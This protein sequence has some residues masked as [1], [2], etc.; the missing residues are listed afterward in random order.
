M[1]L[2]QLAL[3]VRPRSAWEAVDLG[4]L[5]AKR[6][7]WPLM[8]VWLLASAP[9]FVFALCMP[10]NYFWVGFILLWW[11]KPLYERPMLHILSR[12][13]FNELPSTR[14]TLQLFPALARLQLFL[15]LSVRRFSPTRSM[16]L[17]VL[18]LEGLTKARRQAR[19]SILHREDSAPAG[20]LSFIGFAL[21]IFLT[22]GLLSLL[23][24]FIPAEFDV[25]W[26]SLFGNPE[27]KSLLYL[28]LSL[29]YIALGLTAP[30]Y[31]ACGFALYINRRV[32]L[33][34]WDLEIAFRRIA[35][36]RAETP[37][38]FGGNASPLSLLGIVSLCVFLLLGSN[39][40]SYADDQLPPIDDQL[41]PIERPAAE[42]S[43]RESSE[44]FL[45]HTQTD[46]KDIYRDPPLGDYQDIDR[47]LAQQSIA[48]VMQQAEFSRKKIS[49]SLTFVEQEENTWLMDFLAEHFG[50][51][52][53]GVK[54]LNLF[55]FIATFL[56]IIL[57]G[58]ALLL[59][60]LLLYR[61]RHWLAAQFVRV[62]PGK[63][64]AHSKPQILFGLE[65]TEESLPD[66]IGAN[67]LRLL[68]QHNNRAALAL[69]YRASLFR[70]IQNGL[71]IHHGHTEGECVQLFREALTTQSSK[72]TSAAQHA[73]ELKQLEYFAQLT[74]CWQQLAYGH[75]APD[76]VLAENLCNSWNACWLTSTGQ[77]SS[78]QSKAGAV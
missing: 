35:N 1:N 78:A 44:S 29:W 15:S 63:T 32:K 49:R 76:F 60:A 55:K 47:K 6:W 14:N 48:E 38:G 5:M 52:F 37:A 24:A 10:M 11:L 9:V 28:N 18:Q 4:L 34:A 67:A 56:E 59:I 2:N 23:W 22:L 58:T 71:E 51:L 21:E 36:K 13:I 68:H 27:N 62:A 61:Y 72:N 42:E 43:I 50:D 69:L 39:Q 16:D 54:E 41:P 57:W 65:V 7:W 74:S 53:E 45:P 64:T 73:T 33:E 17:P 25:D 26:T 12:A 30:F 70:L 3:E 31:T 20:W 46:D 19:L 8:K 77:P 66:D 40:Q 75:Q